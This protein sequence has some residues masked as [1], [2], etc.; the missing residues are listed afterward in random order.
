VSSFDLENETDIL[1]V[2][3]LQVVNE[4][5]R[6]KSLSLVEVE[7]VTKFFG[8]NWEM[9][10][11]SSFTY[12]LDIKTTSIQPGLIGIEGIVTGEDI[13]VRIETKHYYGSKE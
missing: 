4:I 7:D 2:A 9:A 5:E 13:K 6:I 11:A 8:D 10:D 3:N 12:R 1:E